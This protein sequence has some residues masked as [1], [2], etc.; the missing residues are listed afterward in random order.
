MKKVGIILLVFTLLA[1]CSLIPQINEQGSKDP[2]QVNPSKDLALVLKPNEQAVEY[3]GKPVV[4]ACDIIT[5]DDLEKVGLSLEV[6]FFALDRVYFDGEGKGEL[7][8][9]RGH[10]P[11]M[12][13]NECKYVV[14]GKDSVIVEVYE[15]SYT[16]Q[17]QLDYEMEYNFDAIPDIE[18]VKA[19][20]YNNEDI[21][22][23]RLQHDSLTVDINF[24]FL[25]VDEKRE[26]QLLPIVAKRLTQLE[27]NPTGPIRAEY[28]SDLFS[29]DFVN[30]CDYI[31]NEDFQ[32]LFGE[33][34][35]PLVSEQISSSVRQLLDAKDTYYYIEHRCARGFERFSGEMKLLSIE[36]ESHVDAQSAAGT[37]KGMK[38]AE[39]NPAIGNELQEINP[40]GDE[41]Y[42]SES[43]DGI[44]RIKFRQGRVIVGMSF[45][46]TELNSTTEQKIERLTPIAQAVAERMKDL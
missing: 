41:S 16:S 18:G 5:V 22:E 46:D 45:V 26:K 11:S 13:T 32:N 17:S 33:D 28:E 10:R 2:D 29:A 43:E 9:P 7:E 37:F 14:R 4:Q 38:E 44:W 31:K 24:N 40:I 36:T 6:P 8:T 30:G 21:R 12:N 3:K 39:T 23:Y 19:Y 1:G 15:P 35:G 34:A 27:G 25:D 20:A 42:Y